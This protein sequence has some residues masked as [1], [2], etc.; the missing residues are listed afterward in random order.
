MKIDYNATS[1]WG[2]L[3]FIPRSSWKIANVFIDYQSGLLVVNEQPADQSKLKPNEFGTIHVPN[4]RYIVDI[5]QQRILPAN[6]WTQL[7]D[8]KASHTMTPDEKYELV[9]Q[10]TH[11]SDSELDFIEE[12]LIDRKSGKVITSG[13]RVA[14]YEKAFKNLYE[15]HLENQEKERKAKATESQKLSLESHYFHCLSKLKEKDVLLRYQNP[16]GQIYRLV[17]VEGKFKFQREEIKTFAGSKQ[18]NCYSFNQFDTSEAAWRFMTQNPEW[19][20]R[21]QPLWLGRGIRLSNPLYKRNLTQLA[22]QIRN[23]TQ[24]NWVHYQAIGRWS[25]LL[26]A[27]EVSGTEYLQ[28]CPNCSNRVSLYPRYPTYI[29]LDCKSLITDK[30]GQALSFSNTSFSGGCQGYYVDT[31]EKY[32][33]KDCYIGEKRFVAKEARFGGIVIELYDEARGMI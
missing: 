3:D 8:Y 27:P 11:N 22:N 28:I 9:Q 25:N 10:R 16:E 7:F 31:N 18:I 6:E 23:S 15:R 4:Q 32:E 17:Y 20:V 2:N 19:F 33:G 1:Q 30:Q 5:G 26:Y 14:F 24:I 21:Y 12:K 13:S 29:C